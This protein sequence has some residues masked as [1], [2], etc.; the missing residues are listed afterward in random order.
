LLSD[1][2][3]QKRLQ[4]A[5]SEIADGDVLEEDA[6]RELLTRRHQPKSPG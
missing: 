2:E 3:A 1:P 5:E 6:V 4:I